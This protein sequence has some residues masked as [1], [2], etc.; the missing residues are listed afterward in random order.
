MSRDRRKDDRSGRRE[1]QRGGPQR[2]GPQRMAGGARKASNESQGGG[3]QRGDVHKTYVPSTDNQIRIAFDKKKD[4]A[5]TGGHL[6]SGVNAPHLERG[7][8]REVNQ[9]IKQGWGT[10]AP[11]EGRF[12]TQV[13]NVRHT[14]D[15]NGPG[16]I[17][18]HRPGG[19]EPGRTS[20]TLYKGKQGK[21]DRKRPERSAPAEAG[22][23]EGVEYGDQGSGAAE[24]GAGFNLA[25][26][27]VEPAGAGGPNPDTAVRAG[28]GFLDSFL[29]RSATSTPISPDIPFRPSR[30]DDDEDDDQP[31]VV[32]P[33]ANPSGSS[34]PSENWMAYA[35]R[36]SNAGTG[37][38]APRPDRIA[39]S[40]DFLQRLSYGL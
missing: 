13:V 18:G 39:G 38:Q 25:E 33:P 19:L 10:Q 26:F 12:K 2:G 28:D 4:R 20:L 7:S 6:A 1:P 14:G 21:G 35:E 3:P 9:L 23:P 34:D 22:R 40:P 37:L 17:S 5:H 31:A 24:S 30:Y 32:T 15:W 16:V 36:Y 27:A 29:S 8:A 11:E